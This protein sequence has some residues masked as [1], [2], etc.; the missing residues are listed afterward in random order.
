[1][2]P[3]ALKLALEQVYSIYLPKGSHPFI[4]IN[5]LLE[6]SN[7]DVN[8]HPTKH[9]V[10][11]LH[12]DEIIERIKHA[13]ENKL[14]NSSD[15]RTF[16]TQQLLPGAS[17]PILENDKSKEN[18]DKPVQAKDIIRSDAKSQKLEKF[19]GQTIL[20]P[21]SIMK[22]MKAELNAPESP[23]GI[24]PTQNTFRARSFVEGTRK[25]VFLLYSFDLLR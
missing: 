6:S 11:F 20:S 7:V 1:M 13:F 23:V 14:V 5:L 3:A 22:K 8:V 24:A 4:Y 2:L 16:Y 21:P 15:A 9:E 18:K 19:F 12:E 17:N 10:N 25:Y